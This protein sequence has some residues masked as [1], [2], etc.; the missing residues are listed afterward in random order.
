M[1]IE[2]GSIQLTIDG[3]R[4]DLNRPLPVVAFACLSHS[5]AG[6]EAVVTATHVVEP[7]LFT[8][9]RV[10]DELPSVRR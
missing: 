3:V 6:Y 10:L 1:K 2:S 7:E 5:H 9:S 8:Y 4:R